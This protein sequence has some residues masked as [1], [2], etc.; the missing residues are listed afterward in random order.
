MDIDFPLVTL[1]SCKTLSN[2]AKQHCLIVAEAVILTV[3]SVVLLFFNWKHRPN[4]EAKGLSFKA[5]DDDIRMSMVWRR[6]TES[7][8][9][10]DR[11]VEEEFIMEG[12]KLSGKGLK[13][14]G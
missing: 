3:G 10:E 2:N 8:Y 1:S 7:L 4:A 11:V 6:R 9:L 14:S 5:C 13:K 12:G